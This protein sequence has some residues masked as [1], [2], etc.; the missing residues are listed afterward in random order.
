MTEE[1]VT[2]SLLDY[3][4]SNNWKIICFDFPQSGTGRFI[5]VLNSSKNKD[6]INPD[7]IAYKN[8]SILYFEN[9]G[10]YYFKDFEKIEKIKTTIEYQDSL[11]KFLDQY[12]YDTIYYGIGLPSAEYSKVSKIASEK[13]DFILGVN[14]NKETNVLLCSHLVNENNIFNK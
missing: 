10:Y 13:V 7:I 2:K 1:T 3:L 14:E 6:S 8:K 11:K 4:I 12:D 9:K 5:Q